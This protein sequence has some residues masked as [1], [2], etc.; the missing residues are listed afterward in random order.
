MHTPYFLKKLSVII[1]KLFFQFTFENLTR[2]VF[3]H[4]IHNDKFFGNLKC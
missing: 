1:R 4:F 3:R 2:R